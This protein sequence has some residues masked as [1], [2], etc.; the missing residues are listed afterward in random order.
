MMR[1]MV[2]LQKIGNSLRATI[3]K[4]AAEALSLREGE[5]VIVDVLGDSVVLK[6]SRVATDVT[7]FY[8]VLQEKTGEVEHWPSPEEIKNIWE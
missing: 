8:G 3:P 7:R 4:E 6:K 1:K 5:E 2:R